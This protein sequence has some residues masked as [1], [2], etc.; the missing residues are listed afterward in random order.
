MTSQILNSFIRRAFSNSASHY[1][2][3][4]G[5]Q[6]EIGRELIKGIEVPA[7]CCR[8]LDIGMGTGKLANRLILSFPEAK[9]VGLDFADGMVAHAKKIY[10]TFQIVQANALALPFADE[11]F[12]AAVSNLAYQWVDDLAAAFAEARRILKPQGQLLATLFGRETLDELFKSLERT[13]PSPGGVELK[14]LPDQGIIHDSLEAAGF[15]DVGVT[16]EINKTHFESMNDLL[17]WLKSIGANAMNRDYYLGPRQLE[18][19]AEYYEKN[20]SER[21]GV[22]ASFEVIWIKGKK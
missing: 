13:G 20:F 2:V 5:M 17:K 22:T 15:R 19:A 12:D 16:A 7:D 21:W 10:D 6:Y 9:V 8:I 18:R 3:L 14:R 4:A 11:T 1:E